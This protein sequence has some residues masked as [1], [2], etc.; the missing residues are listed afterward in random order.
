MAHPSDWSPLQCLITAGTIRPREIVAVLGK[1][2]G[3]GC[4]NDFTRAYASD[5]LRAMLTNVNELSEQAL[6]V[7]VMSGGTEGVL[8]PH[9][10]VFVRRP[11]HSAAERLPSEPGLMI[12]AGRSATLPPEHLG[13]IKQAEQV[14]DTVRQCLRQGEI[15]RADVAY[16]QVKCPLLTAARIK[17]AASRGA[18]VATEDTYHSMALSRAAAALGVALALVEVT[19][20]HLDGVTIGKAPHLYSAV[21]SA[22]AGIELDHHEVF[23]L[24]QSLLA[25]GD[26][27]IGHAVM[28]HPLDVAA[29]ARALAG[30]ARSAPDAEAR[31]ANV[32]QVLAK[33][34]APP[35]GTVLGSRHTML[36]DSDIPHSRMAR[37]VVGAVLAS[38]AQRTALYVSGGAECQGPPGGGPLAV[39]YRRPD[40]SST[41]QFAS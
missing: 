29:F 22:S 19:A 20:Q 24:G 32:V 41:V 5:T 15:A 9:A 6:P 21:A 3:N 14:A 27:R 33:A 37:A 26:L 7:I 12:A 40:L 35:D 13:T 17:D 25:T 1:T 8:S 28:Q 34:E 18:A 39:I 4:V 2:E 31:L 38:A 11:V 23:V 10:T 16:V 30:A 36:D